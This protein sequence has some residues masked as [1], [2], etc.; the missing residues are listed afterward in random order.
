MEGQD[1]PPDPDKPEEGPP[2][3]QTCTTGNQEN[4]HS[5]KDK[6]LLMQRTEA[7]T[8][9][10][11]QEQEQNTHQHLPVES[12]LIQEAKDPPHEP[13][14]KLSE[15]NKPKLSEYDLTAQLRTMMELNNDLPEQ[16]KQDT[17]PILQQHENQD[18]PT[19]KAHYPQLQTTE[20]A[21]LLR[22][23]TIVF[24]QQNKSDQQWIRRIK[25]L[26]TT[27]FDSSR[28]LEDVI[29]LKDE[30][31]EEKQ[32]GIV[33]FKTDVYSSDEIEELR[34]IYKTPYEFPTILREPTNPE[35]RI[36]KGLLEG[37]ILA[38]E[39]PQFLKRTC[40]N[41][42][43]RVIQNTMHAQVEGELMIRLPGQFPVYPDFQTRDR[44]RYSILQGA[45]SKGFNMDELTQMLGETKQVCYNAQQHTVHLIYW[46]REAA[47][48]WAQTY[49][50][51]PFRNRR[52]LLINIYP[53]DNNEG[54][55]A[56]EQASRVRNRQIG[57]DG[58]A[59]ARQHDRY[60]I[61]LLN[62][63]RFIDEAGLEEMWT[64]PREIF[65]TQNRQDESDIHKATTDVQQKPVNQHQS[66]QSTNQANE[67]HTPRYRGRRTR[68]NQG[69][70]MTSTLLQQSN[71]FNRNHSV[72]DTIDL[73]SDTESQQ[74]NL[75]NSSG[76]EPNN[77][78]ATPKR[79]LRTSQLTKQRRLIMQAVTKKNS[80][81]R[82]ET[83]QI[84]EQLDI[85]SMEKQG[86][87]GKKVME[88][89]GLSEVSTPDT[90][91]CQYYSMAMDLLDKDFS[92]EESSK[93]IENL[94]A[95]VKKGQKMALEHGCEEEYSHAE[96]QTRLLSCMY[97]TSNLTES[98]TKQQLMEYMEDVVS[99]SSKKTSF[100][101]KSL[102][103][104]D[105][106]LHLAT[107]LLQR[108]IFVLIATDNLETA[109]YQIYEPQRVTKTQF[110]IDTAG[111]YTISNDKSKI[112]I[113]RLQKECQ[114]NE[115]VEHLPIVLKYG[116]QHYSRLQ[117]RNSQDDRSTIT[118]EAY[119]QA[120]PPEDFSTIIHKQ[121]RNHDRDNLPNT[122]LMFHNLKQKETRMLLLSNKEEHK[123]YNQNHWKSK[124]VEKTS[125]RTLLSSDVISTTT[126][127]NSDVEMENSLDSPWT[128]P[129]PT[130]DEI[131]EHPPDPPE[132]RPVAN[133]GRLA[134]N[135]GAT[136]ASIRGDPSQR[137]QWNG[138]E[139]VWQ[140][141]SSLVFPNL[142]ADTKA[143]SN[144]VLAH[145]HNFF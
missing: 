9:S 36:I 54:E 124:Y 117:F 6:S 41:E 64:V 128:P 52:F 53:D 68:I 126:S 102:W 86:N 91:N 32:D 26:I 58:I 46:T 27:I 110:T 116:H 90:G 42:M 131:M 112:W 135:R 25:G 82:R 12:P 133:T 35:K 97:D 118:A 59:H 141:F 19:A 65:A 111:E 136:K 39:L 103:G 10:K 31:M 38:Q 3:Q 81:L 105:F 144:A 122:K 80:K 93:A 99:S 18:L 30:L 2:P 119:P 95:K 104:T 132:N 23:C 114:S 14:E 94:T 98:Q 77:T 108:P 7:N 28:P 15:P 84:L 129:M 70:T 73:V 115:P 140:Q 57:R 56:I 4:R 24:T 106:T 20:L 47:T 123:K 127:E 11:P 125:K 34:S 78:V 96:G 33:R 8:D 137:V 16:E 71:N 89:C 51:L 88:L 74:T 13:G 92:T 60:R 22:L 72:G 40:N 21:G 17:K 66:L 109:T 29:S 130:E 101:A 113:Q 63:S 76:Q 142:Q 79:I 37:M 87:T 83:T 62:I 134:H 107:K 138:L 145:P 85:D 1:G 61:R 49:K 120:V 121:Q 143:W 45:K 139:K 55:T 44:L 67:W 100:I 5:K 50:S 48:K 43:L 75:E 69:T